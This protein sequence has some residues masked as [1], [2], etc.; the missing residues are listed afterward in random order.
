V[1]RANSSDLIPTITSKANAGLTT[2]SDLSNKDEEAKTSRKTSE[3][4]SSDD[5]TEDINSSEYTY[6]DSSS[7]SDSAN[8]DSSSDGSS[9]SSSDGSD[10]SDSDHSS[11]EEGTSTDE[12]EIENSGATEHGMR[13]AETNKTP[14]TIDNESSSESK[15]DD[16]IPASAPIETERVS[17]L[18]H[19]TPSLSTVDKLLSTPPSNTPP[20]EAEHLKPRKCS[21]SASHDPRN[22]PVLPYPEPTSTKQAAEP[23]TESDFLGWGDSVEPASWE[24]QTMPLD[25]TGILEEQRRTVFYEF[26]DKGNGEGE[27]VIPTLQNPPNYQGNPFLIGLY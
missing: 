13:R 25:C 11:S 6:S 19:S 21:K 9:D 10:S 15:L 12:D 23:V 7:E 8:I 2:H 14:R 24:W 26:R 1:L 20:S 16:D 4:S 27:W 5:T 22:A 18:T 3:M 17:T